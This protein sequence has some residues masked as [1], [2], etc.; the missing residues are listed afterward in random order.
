M[1][2]VVEITA[3]CSVK[4]NMGNY[5]STDFFLSMKAEVDEFEDIEEAQR[6]LR[7]KVEQAM[8]A[9]LARAYKVMGKKVTE[10]DLAKR[11]GISHSAG[12]FG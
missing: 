6:G 7:K 8:M 3:S 11:H 2:E 4:L 5:Q 1:A 10:Q 12:E 9:Q